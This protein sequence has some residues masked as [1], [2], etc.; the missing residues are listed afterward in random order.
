MLVLFSADAA[1]V[2][3]MSSA[4]RTMY[5]GRADESHNHLIGSKI[6]PISGVGGGGEEDKLSAV[7][8]GRGNSVGG[9]D[10]K[11]T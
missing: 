6:N 9:D 4:A 7:Q 5:S 3:G 1:G 10:S 8:F 2:G 11:R